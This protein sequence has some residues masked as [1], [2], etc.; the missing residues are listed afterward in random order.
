MSI[1]LN[2]HS[3][4]SI[5][6]ALLVSVLIMCPAPLLGDSFTILQERETPLSGYALDITVSGDGQYTFVLTSAGEVAIYRGTG[7][8][9]QTLKVGKGFNSVQYSATGNRLILGGSGKQKLKILTL[10]MLYEMDYSGSPFKG[11]E[12][13]PVTIA[14]FNDFQ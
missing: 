5:W 2:T 7:D 11:P 8:L 13:A 3:S 6:T 1:E 12:S 10:S 14:V 4:L 9:I